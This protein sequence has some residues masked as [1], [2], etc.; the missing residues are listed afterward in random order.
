MEVNL[1]GLRI[2]PVDIKCNGSRAFRIA[3]DVVCCLDLMLPLYHGVKGLKQVTIAG[4]VIC[5][6]GVKNPIIGRLI[7]R[8][9]IDRDHRVWSSVRDRVG[10]H[11]LDRVRMYDPE[12]ERLRLG[13]RG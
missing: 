2:R 5:S 10:M 7:C 3:K 11:D 13:N 8:C 9:H 1:C 6:S 4:D 12:E